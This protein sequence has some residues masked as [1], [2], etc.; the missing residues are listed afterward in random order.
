MKNK[1]YIVHDIP[2]R[3]RLIIS[4]LSGR[5]DYKYIEMQSSSVHGIKNIRIEPLNNSMVIEYDGN[6]LPR[7]KV[8]S[9]IAVFIEQ[10]QFIPND[11]LMAHVTP[12]VRRNLFYSLLTGVLLFASLARKRSKFIRY[13]LDYSVMIASA[14][15]VLSHSGKDS[16]KHQDVLVGTLGMLSLGPNKLL[17]T[18]AIAWGVNLIEIFFKMSQGSSIVA[19]LTKSYKEVI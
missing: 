2:G 19:D 9:H 5:K 8:L 1:Y 16:L 6:L 12:K 14:Y 15:T 11:G 7:N 17:Q 10:P 13:I 3:L 4:A 18:F